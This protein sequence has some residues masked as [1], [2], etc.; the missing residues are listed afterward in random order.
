MFGDVGNILKLK[1]IISI[2]MGILKDWKDRWKGKIFLWESMLGKFFFDIV[3][4]VLGWL[5]GIIFVVKYNEWVER[6]EREEMDEWNFK[7]E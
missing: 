7:L 4:L 1:F 2:W 3:I 6:S 5:V